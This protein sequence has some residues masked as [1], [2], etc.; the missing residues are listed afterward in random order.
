[1][2]AKSAGFVRSTPTST[3]S[4]NV[5]PAACAGVGFAYRVDQPEVISWILDNAVGDVNVATI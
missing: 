4:S 2:P 5:A 3:T 1:M